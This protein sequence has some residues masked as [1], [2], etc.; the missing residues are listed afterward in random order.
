[1]SAVIARNPNSFSRAL[2]R[3]LRQPPRT[4]EKRWGL[5]F[6]RVTAAAIFFYLF[7]LLAK[8]LTTA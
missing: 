6:Y 8:L 7:A 3:V 5:L 4:I 2:A 1:M